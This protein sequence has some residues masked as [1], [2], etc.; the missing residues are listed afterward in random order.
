VGALTAD[1]H[2]EL[3]LVRHGQTEWSLCGQHTGTTDIPL[4]A[5]GEK[6]ARALA[7]PLRQWDFALVLTSPLIRARETCRLAGLGNR[8]EVCDEL[9]EW[10]YGDY[11]GLTTPQIRERWP[12]WTLFT[13]RAPNGET[14]DEVA[15]RADRVI[16]RAL[17]A[18]RPVVAFAHGHILRV[19]C[20]R[21]L[22]LA[23][24]SARL[25]GLDP[26]TI[27]VLG[28]ERETRVIQSWNV[29]PS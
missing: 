17:S 27:S 12:G 15:T 22:G 13:G 23:A 8:A 3:V 24:N 21:W 4:T 10:N 1:D 18:D 11:E 16:E 7:A 9:R 14:A 29:S 25:F 6:E 28:H 5:T 19:V 20:A 2:H 26:G